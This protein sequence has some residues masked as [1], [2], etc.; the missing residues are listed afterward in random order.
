MIEMSCPRCGAGGRVPNNKTNSRLVCKKCLQVF[1]LTPSGHAVVGEPPPP[2]EAP[3]PRTPREQVEFDLSALEGLGQKLAKLKLPDVKTIAIVSLVLL[4]VGGIGWLLSRESIET[5][6]QRVAL[7]IS[8]GD[9]ETIVNLA[10]PGTEMEAMK[11]AVESIKEHT[12]LKVSLGMQDPAMTVQVQSNTQGSSAQ[13]LVQ[14]KAE[15]GRRAGSIPTEDLQAV[16]SLSNA[17][18]SIELILH[19]TPDTWGNW[20]LDAKRTSEAVTPPA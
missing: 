6:S 1:H 11:W 8:K 4:V 5:R 7:A 16:P 14:Y 12:E 13:A 20:R 2:K 10:L 18:K 9:V 15:G 17:K 3:R 19:W